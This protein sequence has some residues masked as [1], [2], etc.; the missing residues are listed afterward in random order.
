MK[1]QYMYIWRNMYVEKR[2]TYGGRGTFKK[3]MFFSLFYMGTRIRFTQRISK[4]TCVL[5]CPAIS[6]KTVDSGRE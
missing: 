6:E 4:K 2:D 3:T 1:V 5:F